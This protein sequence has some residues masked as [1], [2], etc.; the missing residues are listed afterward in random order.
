MFKL[1][2]LLIHFLC[3]KGEGKKK[4]SEVHSIVLKTGLQVRINLETRNKDTFHT[5]ML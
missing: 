2:S 5:G 1:N 4:G 3:R